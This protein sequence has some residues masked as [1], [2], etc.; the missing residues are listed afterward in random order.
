M[1]AEQNNKIYKAHNSDDMQHSYG[2]ETH[3]LKG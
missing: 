2:L 1:K 3:K